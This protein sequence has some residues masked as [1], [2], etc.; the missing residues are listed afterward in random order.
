MYDSDMGNPFEQGVSSSESPDFSMIMIPASEYTI[1]Q[2]TS[3]GP[4]GQRVNKVATRA[5][6]RFDILES[7]TLTE[8]QKFRVLDWLLKN[9]P[10]YL[11]Q[12]R[13]LFIKDQQGA[14]F[15][16]NK[17]RVVDQLHAILMK[18]LHVQEER[19]P[20]KPTKGSQERR[21]AEKT[22][23]GKKKEGRGK[24]EHE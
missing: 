7:Q 21:I 8:E 16:R 22:K 11:V 3:Q 17:K 14:E 10:S 12:D 24:V 4:G 19:K 5:E 1:T 9:K 15:S 13:M 2:N 6:L 20:T 18:A 23:H